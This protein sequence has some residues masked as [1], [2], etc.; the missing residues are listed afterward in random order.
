M[1]P[2]FADLV[3]LIQTERGITKDL[4][5]ATIEEFLIAAYNRTFGTSENAVVKFSESGGDVSIFARKAIVET[6]D[7]YDPVTEIELSEALE[8]NEDCEVG[9]ELLIEI[10]PKNFDRGAIQSAKQKARQSLREIQKDTLYSEFRGKVG[11]MIIGYFQREKN[12]TIFVDLGRIE[13]IL[14]RRFQSP[15]EEYHHGDRIKAMIAEVKK[16]PTGLEIILSRSHGEF[17]KRIFELEVPEIYDGTVEIF[18][19]VREPG[20]R[21]KVAVYSTREDVDPV[22]SCVGLKGVRIQAI[23][24]ELEGEKIDILKYDSD[25]I[26]F[27][28]NALGSAEVQ[29]VVILDSSKRQAL[30]IVPEQQLSLAI[31]KQGLNVRLANRLVDWSIDVKTETQFAEM[32]V[33]KE[34]S[35]VASDLF[36]GIDS[37]GEEIT[38]IGELPGISDRLVSVLK[39]NGIE[40]IETLVSLAKEELESLA[41]LTPSDVEQIQKIIN[42]NVEII[43][44]GEDE[45]RRTEKGADDA[46]EK[47]VDTYECPNCAQSITAD[48][49]AC[50]NCGVGLSFEA[51]EVKEQEDN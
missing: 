42:D 2:D 19:I 14:P 17:V 36:S 37:G 43:E 23:V 50:P 12:G 1:N 3:K 13:G 41:G 21:T 45:V 28:R 46:G 25:P 48:M 5:L 11:E 26:E 51:E 4:V 27:I 30:A 44:D 32:D 39:E 8:L 22:G 38:K 7:L 15:R 40:L 33:S 29:D 20:F 10:D 47:T 16:A 35:R 9:D 34:V 24:R 49:S 18:K 31:G 6:D